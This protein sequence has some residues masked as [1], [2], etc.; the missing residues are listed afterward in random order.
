MIAPLTSAVRGQPLPSI[1]EPVI[2][3]R[4]LTKRYGRNI[5]H[6]HLNFEVRR[7]EIVS[8]EIGRAHV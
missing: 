6:Q 7:G 3:V 1:A 5:V 2:E 4:D 8:I